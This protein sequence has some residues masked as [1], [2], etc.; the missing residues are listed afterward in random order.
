MVAILCARYRDLVQIVTTCVQIML[1][2]TPI[3][4]PIEM[5]Q[6]A[7]YIA[8]VN[9]LHHILDWFGRRFS[10]NLRPPCR[11]FT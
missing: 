4:W 2:V 1:F 7:T 8:E 6:G 3:M 10:V 11:G 9:P 5:L